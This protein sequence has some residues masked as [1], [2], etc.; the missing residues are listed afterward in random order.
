MHLAR[1][2]RVRDGESLTQFT[3][4][5]AERLGVRAKIM[6]TSDD[7]IRTVVQTSDGPLDFQEYFV[8]RQCEPA[9]TALAYAG[10]ESAGISEDTL[11]WLDDPDLAAIV[12]CPSN[13]YLSIAPVLAAGDLRRRICDNPAPVVAVSPLV[14]G[15]AVKGPTAKIMRELGLNV[16]NAT[17]AEYYEGIIDGFIIDRGDESDA[18]WIEKNVVPCMCAQTLMN[19]DEDKVQLARDTLE[20]ANVLKHQLSHR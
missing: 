8:R 3:S 19:S 7:P 17:I 10:A 2:R 11:G 6:P 18:G 5:V 15:Q 12:I 20:F 4:E 16:T 13:P 1:T 14:G 9:V